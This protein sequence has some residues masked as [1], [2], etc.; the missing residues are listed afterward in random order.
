MYPDADSS[1]I[2]VVPEGHRSQKKEPE[3]TA[4]LPHRNAGGERRNKQ[5]DARPRWFGLGGRLTTLLLIPAV[6]ASFLVAGVVA[7][8]AGAAT[9]TE[10]TFT[11]TDATFVVQTDP[12][13][14]KNSLDYLVATS[15]VYR[16]FLKFNTAS[17]GTKKITG[18]RLELA[19]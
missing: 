7:S 15:S 18:A 12:K 11:A 10:V 3:M 6:G 13:A 1:R 17:L 5:E 9:T 19:V 16:T 2:E 8:Q 4:T 14:N